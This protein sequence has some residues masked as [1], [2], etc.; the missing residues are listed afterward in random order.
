MS[1]TECWTFFMWYNIFYFLVYR[2]SRYARYRSAAAKLHH[3]TVRSAFIANSSKKSSSLGCPTLIHTIK[4]DRPDGSQ[5]TIRFSFRSR[6]NKCWPIDINL[7]RKFNIIR[8]C[9][10]FINF[11]TFQINPRYTKLFKHLSVIISIKSK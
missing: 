8:D 10:K 9:F 3:P 1:N 7:I 5:I 11:N 2:N 4:R 6:S